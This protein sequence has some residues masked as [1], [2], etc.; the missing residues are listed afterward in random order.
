MYASKEGNYSTSNHGVMEMGYYEVSIVHSNI[1][2]GGSKD[3][4]CKSTTSK[5]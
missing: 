1:K 3:Y 2:R 5:Q 4:S